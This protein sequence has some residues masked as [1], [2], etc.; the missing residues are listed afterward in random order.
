ME[1]SFSS[2][3]SAVLYGF[4]LLYLHMVYGKKLSDLLTWE[5]G[6]IFFENSFLI[7]GLLPLI[8]AKRNIAKNAF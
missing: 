3:P 2:V 4:S 8:A 7:L 5:S 1:N 6:G